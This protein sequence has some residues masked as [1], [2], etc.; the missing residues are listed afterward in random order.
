MMVWCLIG[1]VLARLFGLSCLRRIVVAAMMSPTSCIYAS[2]SVRTSIVPIRL[3]RIATR[4][5]VKPGRRVSCGEHAAKNKNIKWSEQ[6]YH[7]R[8]SS[9]GGDVI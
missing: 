4:S 5:Q 3:A 8:R 6:R 1:R 2:V 9:L 7:G